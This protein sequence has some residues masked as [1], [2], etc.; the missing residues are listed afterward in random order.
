MYVATLEGVYALRVT[1]GTGC[2]S[3]SQPVSVTVFPVLTPIISRNGNMLSSAGYV[4]YQWYFNNNPIPGATNA[5]LSITQN[6]Y[7]QVSGTDANGCTSTSAI[8]WIQNL[9]IDNQI[10]ADDIKIF[11]NPATTEVHIVSPVRVNVAIRNMQGQIVL[12]GYAVTTMNISSLA[13]GVY[14]ISILDKDGALLKT[15]RLVKSE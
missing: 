13:N 9:G 15:G 5:D 7:Y 11:P 2:T 8:A 10:R 6:G 1:A 12:S 4:T 14:M 3:L